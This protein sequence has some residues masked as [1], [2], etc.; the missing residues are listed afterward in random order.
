VLALERALGPADFVGRSWLTDGH[1]APGARR[2]AAMKRP[3]ALQHRPRAVVDEAALVAALHSA[4]SAAP[5][6]S[7]RRAAAGEH[8]LGARPRR[9]DA[10]ISG[11]H[12]AE[13][14]P[15][16]NDTRPLLAG[17]PL[18]TSWIALEVLISRPSFPQG[19]QSRSARGRATA[20]TAA[21]IV[22]A[23]RGRGS[24]TT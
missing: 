12:A 14:A 18:R 13:L 2:W 24:S 17:R 1:E 5:L 6:D 22:R 23:L 11:R 15:V 21:A 19:L 4:A 8:P 9:P 3:V 20:E 7:S 16:F 10:A